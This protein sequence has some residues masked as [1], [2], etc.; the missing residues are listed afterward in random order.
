M[1]CDDTVNDSLPKVQS[2]HKVIT[3]LPFE[4]E[5][6]GFGRVDV[7]YGVP[8]QRDLLLETGLRG[9]LVGI[10][11]FHQVAAKT[12]GKGLHPEKTKEALY[13]LKESWKDRVSITASFIIGLPGE[14][15]ESIWETVEWLQREDCPVDEAIFSPLNLRAPT[16]DPDS[17]I[18]RLAVE[19]DKF[20]YEAHR[21]QAGA[22]DLDGRA[23]LAEPP[24][25]QGA[26]RAISQADP[27][28]LPGSATR[29]E[30]GR[31]FPA[32]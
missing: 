28:D 3:S 15:E 29:R 23:V 12:V 16:E 20:G 9:M 11:S 24:L 30:L 10:E 8:E 2:L 5:W 17:P 25:R 27:G 6:T 26:S 14:T 7:T 19:P 4:I 32:A 22:G 31:L 18:S 13:Y 1:F 21:Q